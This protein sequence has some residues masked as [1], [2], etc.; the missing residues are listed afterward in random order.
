MSDIEQDEME[1]IVEAIKNDN[2]NTLSTILKKY[3]TKQISESTPYSNYTLFM[4]ACEKGSPQ[5][6]KTF[7][8]QGTYLF[9]VK[10]ADNNEFKSAVSNKKYSYEVVSLLLEMFKDDKK[11]AV[12]ELKSD[13]D[14]CEELDP[15]DPRGG[16]SPLTMLKN[17]KD[18][19]TLALVRK[20]I[21]ETNR[22]PS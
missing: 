16:V 21:R 8:D 7:I 14:Y 11:G 19:K 17:N 10:Y 9:F 20:F 2:I 5:A 15:S 22:H 12:A 6:V 4:Y 18:K 13:G 1:K 3:S